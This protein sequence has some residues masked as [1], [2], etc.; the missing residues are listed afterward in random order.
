MWLIVC[1]GGLVWGT[2]AAVSGGVGWAGR[3]GVTEEESGG[4]RSRARGT[5]VSVH[6]PHMPHLGFADTEEGVTEGLDWR[7]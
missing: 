2:V 7:W 1:R 4:S 3:A 5:Q 6:I